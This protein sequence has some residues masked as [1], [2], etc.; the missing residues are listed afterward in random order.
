VQKPKRGF[1]VEMKVGNKDQG[2]KEHGYV[3]V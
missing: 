2:R 3:Y 1:D